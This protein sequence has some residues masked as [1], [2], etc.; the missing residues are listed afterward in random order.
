MTSQQLRVDVAC[1]GPAGDT[2]A[3][4]FKMTYHP[5]WQVTVDG[6]PVSPYMVSPGFLAVDVLPG[7]HRLEARYVAHPWKLPLLLGGI[8]LF[9]GICVRSDWA[10]RPAQW[11]LHRS[12]PVSAPG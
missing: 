3:V 11:W 2:L 4:A 12:A 5:Q 7:R 6:A 8:L 10:D 9:L 1:P